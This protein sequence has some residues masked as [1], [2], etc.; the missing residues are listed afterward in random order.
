MRRLRAAARRLLATFRRGRMDDELREEIASHLAEATDEYLRRGMSP[1]DARRAALRSFGGVTQV[2]QIHREVRALAWLGDLRQDLRLAGRTLAANPAFAIVAVL[3]LAL[4]IGATTAVFTLLDAVVFKPLPVP[5]ARELFAFYEN[6]PEGAAD[7]LGGTGRFLRFSYARFEQLQRALGSRGSMAAVTRSSRLIVRFPGDADRHFINAQFVSAGYFAT[8]GVQVARGRTLT[9]DDVDIDRIAPVA[10]VSD[11]FWRRSL[12]A[13]EAALGTT[14]AINDVAV[15]VIGIAPRG[16]V[17]MWT[18]SEADVWLPLTLQQPMHY[19]N[20]SSSYGAIDNDRPWMLQGIAWLNLVARVP[21]GD[22]RDVLPQLQAANRDGVVE[23]AGTI[24]NPKDRTAMLTHTFAAES[25][26][27][28]FSGLRARFS[29]ALFVLTGMVTLVLL[30]TCANIANLLLARAAVRAHD[31]RIRISLG[32]TTGR[33]LRQCL[34]ESLA[35]AALGG[36][37]GVLLGNWGSRFLARQ[38][39]DTSGQLPM[40]FAPD[41]RMLWFAGGL[42]VAAA[43]VFGLVPAMRAIAAGRRAAGAHLRQAIGRT[44]LPGMRW[45]VIG[46][47]AL[48]VF[49]VSAALLLGRTLINFMRIDPGFAADGLVTVSFD[50]ITSRYPGDSLPALARR[51]VATATAVPGVAASAASTCGLIAGCSSSGGFRVEGA[52]D[53][54]VSLYRNWVSPGYFATAGIPLVAGREFS[55][56]DGAQSPRVAIVNES[57]ARRYFPAGNAIGRR[58]GA[59]GLDTEIVGV[60]HDARTQTLHDPAVP[61]VYIPIDQKP[62]NAQPTLT[63]LDV[64]IAGAAATIEPALRRAIHEAEPNLLVGDVGAMSR[65]LSRDLTRERV[66]AYLAFGFG[67]L[68]LLLAA[69]G[70]YGVLSYGVARRTQEIGVRMALGARPVQVLRLVGS[71]SAGLTITGMALG[72]LATWGGSRYLSG[73]LFGVTPLD[74]TTLVLVT[75]AF[76][77]VTALASYLPARRA[78]N[79]DPLVALRCE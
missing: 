36:A 10:I 20:N 31:I 60:A 35:L 61:M 55:D 22:V 64:R 78:T 44:T 26:S 67:I 38:V 2:E 47:L 39:L 68:T 21:G 73:M 40:V 19:H 77:V 5:A 54:S 12:G 6:G 58:L 37:C 76:V 46:Q 57:L 4:G 75:L 34:T 69:L 1:D 48:S 52:G 7:P 17:G 66:V 16:F 43:I 24:R 72:L 45:I 51:L 62:P 50:P 42:S 49:L 56:R 74:P 29:D 53:E 13:S 23:L 25:L 9:A 28:G 8:L 59:S 14:I 71:Q 11:G 41:A 33:L 79:V 18:D 27:S 3:T 70:L 30:V 63:N 32:A 15:T 65:R